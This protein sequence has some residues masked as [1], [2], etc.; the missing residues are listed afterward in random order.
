MTVTQ[1]WNFTFSCPKLFGV[2]F[3]KHLA[4]SQ[5]KIS[6]YEWNSTYC[7]NECCIRRYKGKNLTYVTWCFFV[8]P[9]QACEVVRFFLIS[10]GVLTLIR[11][12]EISSSVIPFY[13]FSIWN[14]SVLG[15]WIGI[16]SQ[17]IL[18]ASIFRAFFCPMK[19]WI[20]LKD[21]YLVT[22]S[23]TELHCKNYNSLSLDTKQEKN[24]KNLKNL[25]KD[26]CAF[27]RA[28]G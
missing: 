11:K 25:T 7:H 21:L 27:T 22:K 10:L 28:L 17:L 4:T 20:H 8:V 15:R 14:K 5:K 19:N 16:Y 13:R 1:N 2:C 26:F 12:H 3:I 9:I 24:R 23:N 6:L 18:S